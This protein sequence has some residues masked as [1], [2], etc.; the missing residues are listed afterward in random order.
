MKPRSS[1]GARAQVLDVVAHGDADLGLAVVAEHREGQG[2]AAA[3]VQPEN[4]DVVLA[5]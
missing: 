5:G 2:D 4:E 3:V 1:N